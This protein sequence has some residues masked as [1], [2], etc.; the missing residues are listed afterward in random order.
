MIIVR[1]MALVVVA[2]L[3][4]VIFGKIITW[5]SVAALMVL[6]MTSAAHAK[7]DGNGIEL[8][9]S[10]WILGWYGVF[11]FDQIYIK[12]VITKVKLPT[13]SN[14]F[15]TN[16]LSSL[17]VIPLMSLEILAVDWSTVDRS[18]KAMFILA[19]SCFLGLAMSYF[20]FAAR[21]AF[22]A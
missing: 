7:L 2:A 1:A 12:A 10:W 22:S 18:P 16:G 9:A 14:V 5:R 15:Y 20:S 21:S 17:F 8:Q 3:D 13:W 4:R 19:G 11:C 6:L